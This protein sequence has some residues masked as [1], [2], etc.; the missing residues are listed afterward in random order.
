MKL[1]TCAE[2]TG[3]SRALTRYDFWREIRE[4]KQI[5]RKHKVET[6]APIDHYGFDNS[7]G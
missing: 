7:Y 6:F 5:W 2:K 3:C 4:T 1:E